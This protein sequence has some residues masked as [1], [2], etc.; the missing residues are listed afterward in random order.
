VHQAAQPQRAVPEP[1]LGPPAPFATLHVWTVPATAVP[2]SL[3][4][5]GARQWRRSTPGLR[6]AK[7]C[8]SAGTAG[9]ALHRSRLRHWLAFCTWADPV[10]AAQFDATPFALSWRRRA[11]EVLRLDLRPVAAQGRW[12]RR[13]PFGALAAGPEPTGA[14]AEPTGVVAA[15]T[16][17]RLDPRRQ[18]RFWRA[19]APIE[20]ELAAASPLLA[21]GLSE[22][23]LLTQGTFSI[24]P[25]LAALRAFAY[26]TPAHVQAIEDTPEV[27]WYRE[28]LFARFE[29]VGATG[30]PAAERRAIGRAAGRRPG[31]SGSGPLLRLLD[32]GGECSTSRRRRRGGRRRNGARPR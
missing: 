22:L 7:Q 3:H 11:S 17:A 21:V 4:A 5:M 28:S 8:G 6:F 18:A 9:F 29:V 12:A 1:A 10:A 25:D 31:A 20:A 15:L 26:R 32:V 24:W 14:G 2:V 23:P 13:A 27:G 19:I 30:S 16:R